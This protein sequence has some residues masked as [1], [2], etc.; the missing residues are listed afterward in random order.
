MDPRNLGQAYSG[1]GDTR[2]IDSKWIA[3]LLVGPAPQLVGLSL[4]AGCGKY[5]GAI[6]LTKLNPNTALISKL[7]NQRGS[8]LGGEKNHTVKNMASIPRNSY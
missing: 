2:E 3:T 5:L 7:L 8:H 6:L 4:S 1:W